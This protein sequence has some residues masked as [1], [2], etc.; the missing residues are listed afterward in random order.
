MICWSF[1]FS[2]FWIISTVNQVT[3]PVHDT[4]TFIKT[5]PWEKDRR[6]VLNIA[7][8][9]W[10]RE[11][12]P[13]TY[14]PSQTFYKVQMSG[15]SIT[16]VEC[17][18]FLTNKHME[19]HYLWK[20]KCTIDRHRAW[21]NSVE[22]YKYKRQSEKH[23][24]EARHVYPHNDNVILERQFH[25]TGLRCTKPVGGSRGGPG[26]SWLR[27]CTRSSERPFALPSFPK[28]GKY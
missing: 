23:L 5:P 3:D 4:K 19:R 14:T 18:P 15:A 10:N 25:S 17:Y 6:A 7:T 24:Q 27:D 12:N 26:T 9:N 22:N 16:Q 21:K 1:L 13:L 11:D 28:T 8:W 2:L 20:D